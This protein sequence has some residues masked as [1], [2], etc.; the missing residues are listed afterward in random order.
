MLRV[1]KDFDCERVY[2]IGAGKDEQREIIHLKVGD[3]IRC[4]MECAQFG[5]PNGEFSG[6]YLVS[7]FDKRDNEKSWPCYLNVPANSIVRTY[8]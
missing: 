6:L 7:V 2:R 3:K 1:I 8:E 4:S 5:G